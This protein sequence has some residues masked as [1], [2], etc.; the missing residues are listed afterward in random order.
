MEAVAKTI[1][2]A[3]QEIFIT[4]WMF[5][6]ELH[7]IRPIEDDR[8]RLDNLLIRKAVSTEGRCGLVVKLSY[9]WVRGAVW[10]SG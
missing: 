2:Q 7:L 3:Q 6:P 9:K 1:D 5:S 4:D 10:S 8:Y